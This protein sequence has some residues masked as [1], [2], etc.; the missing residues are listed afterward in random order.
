MY[1]FAHEIHLHCKTMSEN[2]RSMNWSRVGLLV[3]SGWKLTVLKRKNRK[4]GIFSYKTGRKDQSFAIVKRF[5]FKTFYEKFIFNSTYRVYYLKH[6][7]D[8]NFDFSYR[9]KIKNLWGTCIYERLCA[10][11][12]ALNV[13]LSFL[14]PSAL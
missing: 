2:A 1:T 5:L 6:I 12:F 11:P 4:I 9:L 14:K 10:S 3:T 13:S 7:F 8:H